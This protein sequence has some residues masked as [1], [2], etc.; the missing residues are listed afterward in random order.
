MLIIKRNGEEVTFDKSKIERVLTNVFLEYNKVEENVVKDLADIITG[1]VGDG[2]H[3][4]E[5]QDIVE[6]SLIEYGYVELAKAYIKYRENKNKTRNKRYKKGGLSKEFL[7]KYKHKKDPFPT[8]L[9]KFIYYRTYSR[10]LPEEQ[11]REYWWETV[12]RAVEYNCSLAPTS[13]KEMEE[14]FDRVYNFKNFLAGRTLWTGGTEAS[15]KYPM[16]NYNCSFTV[17]DNFKS[18]E[19]L[20]YLL[21]IGAGVGVR[22]LREDV[23]KLPPVRT[24]IEVKHEYYSP[25]AKSERAEFS[26]YEFNDENTAA[27][28]YVGDSKEAWV[29][30]LKILFEF[31]TKHEYRSI[32]ELYFNYNSVRPK[33]ERLKTFGGTASGHESIKK[34]FDK[35]DMVLKQKKENKVKLKPLDC[36]DIANII[37]E[38]VVSGG[39]RRTS[40]IGLFDADNEN[41][42]SAK[43]ELYTQVDGEWQIDEKIEHRQMSNNS[44][45]YK[46]KPTREQLNWHI[47]KMR[48][49]GEPGFINAEEGARRRENFKG[50]NPCAEILLDGN[51]V[52]NLVSLNVKA[53]V[54]NG[55]IDFEDLMKS[56]RM[57]VR[58]AYR[59]A[60]VEFELPEWDY[61]NSRDRLVGLSLTGWQDAMNALGWENEKEK[62][63]GLLRNLK[64]VAEEEAEKVAAEYDDEVPVLVTTVKPEG[65][66]TQMPTVSSGLHYNHSA[67]YIRRV[68]ISASDPLVK[69]AEEL[70]WNVKDEV[71]DNP[72]TK[73]LEFPVKAPKGK[74]KSDVSAIEQLETYKMFMKEYVDHNASITI[75]VRDNEW[76]A[77]EQWLWENWDSVV[78]VSF[79][80]YDDNFYDLMPYEEITEKEYQEMAKNM[81][82]F[83]THLV[84]K[85]ER[86]HQKERELEQDECENG[87][88]PVR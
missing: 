84:N 58:S 75:H 45:Y 68:R 34:M 67:Y 83:K 16:S 13:Q 42:K 59:M 76:E 4:E 30:A 61:V 37:G 50:V 3:V 78:G 17:V 88:C 32:N 33:G 5:I 35:I 27:S 1:K 69:V 38:N 10:W 48:Y 14:L 53:F 71:G 23:E 40:E 62:Q 43:S 28:I 52:C 8:E 47:K 24:D 65:T 46:E 82:T 72:N 41:I 74:I 85:Y 66:Q 73:V 25:V 87:V 29:Q 21:L 70:D 12:K 7:S 60:L 18:Y 51:G 55:D 39:V 54:K 11:R 64:K 44:I 77:V 63:V 86:E 22:V 9:G 57:N 80:S 20:F 6:N 26:R 15:R 36:L 79:I 2:M 49:S 56:Q 19:D 31:L 81:N